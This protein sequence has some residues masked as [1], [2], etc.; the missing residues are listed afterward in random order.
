M[1]VLVFGDSITYGAWDTQAG[2]VERIKRTAHEQTVQS[3]GKNKVQV[4][5]LGIGGDTSTKI[6]KRMPTEIE[7]RYS[8]SWPF[9]FVI[10]FGANDERSIGGKIETPIDQFEA[11]VRDI[12]T[13][14]KRHSDKILFLGIPPIG[15]P[16]VE[17]KG[18][19]YSDERVKEYEQR[20]RSVVEEA[21]LTFVS[22]RTAFEQAGLAGLYS[23]D[24]IHP[25]DSGH[26]LIADTVMPKLTELLSA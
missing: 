23:Y 14:A 1:R 20:L 19:E 10:T 18:Q 7:A 9:V 24:N 6:L 17:F 8:A 25:N 21:G 15:K 13:L 5:N 26:H 3:E 2:W 4:I 16:I 22:I 11:N 12:I